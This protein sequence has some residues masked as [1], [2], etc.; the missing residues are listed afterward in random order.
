VSADVR[1][2]I[3]AFALVNAAKYNGKANRK[4]VLGQIFNRFPE[5]KKRPKETIQL[6]DGIVNEVNKLSLDGLNAEIEKLPPE[7][8]EVKKPEEK[9]ELPPLPNDN[10]PI[11]MRLAPFPSGPLHIGNARMVILNDTYV[12]RYKGQ[13]LLVF[14]DTIGSEEKQIIPDAYDMIV[15]SLDWLGVKFHQKI[16]KSDRITKTYE[17]CRKAI[18]IGF[19]YI[20][21]CP[22]GEWR[23]QYKLK[24]RPCPHRDQSKETNLAEWE[25][26]LDGV[27]EERQAVARLKIG[28]DTPNPAIRDPVM[29]RISKRSHPRV[30]TKYIVWPLLEFSWA[31]DDH[32]LGITHILRGKDLVKEDVI[33]QWVWERFG[34]PII[35]FTHY[36]LIKF[37]GLKLSKTQS[38]LNIESGK[39]IGWHDPRT[40]SLQSL[41]KRG[42]QPSAIRE[43]ILSLG[44]SKTDIEYSPE[45]IYA[46]N[47]KFIDPKALR[48]FFV[49]DPVQLTVA[50][51][52]FSELEAHPL[53]HPEHEAMGRRTIPVSLS[54]GITEVYIPREELTAIQTGEFVRLKDLFN[55][56]ILDAKAPLKGE[57]KSKAMEDA[58]DRGARIV[59]W[60]PCDKNIQIEMIMDDGSLVKGFGEPSCQD[61]E[62]GQVIQFERVG[63]AKIDTVSPT[64]LSAY[65]AH[66]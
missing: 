3:R 59:Q 11:V 10:K 29:M 28:M 44:L 46:I 4:A 47:K 63:F 21:T 57:F 66:K 19:A 17:F 60:V 16:F 53:V 6:V 51:V 20:C 56:E 52:P 12:K 50:N 24:E 49:P 36:G 65:F 7:F 27:Y 62:E 35:D 25:K 42:I 45:A 18:E 1:A 23:E 2:V 14:D 37:K 13:L 48:Y 58:R 15:E 34:W 22:A 33:E 30:G 31:I 32:L 8:T 41:M 39:Y 64:R 26:M 9:K 38:R 55:I 5:F 43:A 61:L 54:D 40:W